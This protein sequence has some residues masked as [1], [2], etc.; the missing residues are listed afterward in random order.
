MKKYIPVLFLSL[1]LIEHSSA[2]VFSE[3]GLRYYKPIKVNNSNTYNYV[4]NLLSA[5]NDLDYVNLNNSIEKKG[6]SSFDTLYAACLLE[7]SSN[8]TLDFMHLNSDLITSKY[9][10]QFFANNKKR[11][12]NVK[13]ITLGRCSDVRSTLDKK[14][15]VELEMIRQKFISEM[16]HGN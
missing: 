15:E 14:T 7:G 10:N 1:F 4:F 3:K 11:L 6:S 12:S 2:D 13:K 5:L 8:S 16:I 9:A